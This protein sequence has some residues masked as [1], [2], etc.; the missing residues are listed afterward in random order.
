[1]S[2]PNKIKKTSQDEAAEAKAEAEAAAF[3]EAKTKTE[4]IAQAEA[5]DEVPAPK[6]DPMEELVDY[7]APLLPGVKKRYILVGVNG[8]TLRIQRGVPV[9]I[10]RKFYEV[11]QNAARQEFAALEAREE[12]RKQGQKS[13]ASM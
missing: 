4:A 7:T 1:M 9:R 12:I 6:V 13:L 5:E 3:E 10:K 2:D 11:L 8:E